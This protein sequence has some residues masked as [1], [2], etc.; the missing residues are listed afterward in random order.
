MGRDFQ[1][2]EAVQQTFGIR[3]GQE[4]VP[5][6]EYSLDGIEKAKH[7]GCV[8]IRRIGMIG[9]ARDPLTMES[10]DRTR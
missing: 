9:D 1:G 5:P 7:R 3:L 4:E 8:L 6:L 2:S 10:L